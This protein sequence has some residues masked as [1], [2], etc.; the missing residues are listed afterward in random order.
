MKYRQIIVFLIILGTFLFILNNIIDVK[1][2]N[3]IIKNNILSN[4]NKLSTDNIIDNELMNI[5]KTEISELNGIT[6]INDIIIVNKKFGLPS[7]YNPGENSVAASNLQ[8]LIDDMQ[9]QGFD[10]NSNYS[11]FRTYEYQDQLY[12]NYVSIDGVELA[13]TY[14]ARPGHSE[15]QTGLSFDILNTDG[16]LIEYTNNSEE[17]V[18]LKNNAHLYGFIIRYLYGKEEYT[19]YMFEPWHIRYIGE[20]ATDIYNSGLSLE[21]F[22][23]FEGGDYF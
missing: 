19:G 1:N 21:E 23:D 2:K 7:G 10:I 20:Q 13:D 9:K 15:H 16:E 18:W 3:T 17:A 4:N 6:Y 8:N 14:S 5:K 11:G 12:S 22:F